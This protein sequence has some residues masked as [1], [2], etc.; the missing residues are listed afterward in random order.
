MLAKE[1]QSLIQE[2][3]RAKGSATVSELVERFGVSVET[4]RRDLLQL[5]RH[6]VLQ[7]VHGGAVAIREMKRNTALP[8]RKEENRTAKAELSETAA[9]LLEDQDVI[10]IDSGATAVCFAEAVR[11]RKLRLTVVTHSADVF[12]LL[13]D[14]PEI[15]VLLCG[16]HYMKEERAFHGV[17]TLEMLRSIHV[18][19]AFVFPSAIS[20]QGGVCDFDHELL[21]VQRQIL[22]SCSRAFFL[23]ESQKFEKHGL[24]KLCD[25]EGCV[26]ITDSSIN[27]QLKQ[28]YAENGIR[29]ITGKE[30]LSC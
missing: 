14:E 20:L 18:D 25:A 16:G 27:P 29:V 5:E 19:K 7:R 17:L 6:G 1:R 2:Q 26:F 30:E 22:H 9:A 4:V 3:L 21:A 13:R 8:K 15:Q 11:A 28:L 23:A 10:G 12:D 24:L